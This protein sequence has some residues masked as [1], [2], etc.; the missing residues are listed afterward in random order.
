MSKKKTIPVELLEALEQKAADAGA[1][2]LIRVRHDDRH[3]EAGERYRVGHAVAG[4]EVAGTGETLVEAITA[5]REALEPS[6]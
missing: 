4:E 1:D 2:V 5:Y 6:E 3:R